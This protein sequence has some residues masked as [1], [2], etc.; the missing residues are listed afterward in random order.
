[1]VATVARLKT[2]YIGGHGFYGGGGVQKTPSALYDWKSERM[3][4]I[5]WKWDNLPFGWRQRLL[6]NFG[7]IEE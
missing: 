5:S 2:K 7:Q 3:Y 6:E 1:M 4:L